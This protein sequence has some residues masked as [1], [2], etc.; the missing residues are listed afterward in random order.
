[1]T[2]LGTEFGV[3]VS[4]S[5]ETCSHVFRGSVQLQQID[6]AKGKETPGNT[7]VLHANEAA[8]IKIQQGDGV[9]GKAGNQITAK[10]IGLV[11]SRADFNATAFVLP[12]QMRQY[13]EQQRLKP[14]RRWQAYSQK[15]RNDPALVA[16]YPFEQ[17]PSDAST[18]VLPNRSAAG[19]ALDGRVAGGDW[20][21][22]RLPGKMALYFHGPHSGDHV[23][24]P[25]PNRFEFPGA[26]T[27]AIWCKLLRCDGMRTK[28]QRQ[29]DAIVCTLIAKS[30]GSWRLHQVISPTHKGELLFDTDTSALLHQTSTGQHYTVGRTCITP[31]VGLTSD[32]PWRFVVAVYQPVG[33]I[34][35]KRLYLD[36]RLDGSSDAPLPRSGNKAPVWLGANSGHGDQEFS[37]NREFSGLIDEV[38]IFSRA[39]SA[40]EI[41]A[42][43]AA[44]N[45]ATTA[46]D[47]A[48]ANWSK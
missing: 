7:I 43:F 16:Y 25:E 21:D 32:S 45:P 44:G 9:K 30:E 23:E 24:L 29:E 18:S 42:M 12:D 47:G 28:P 27:V 48:N 38:A 31:P 41:A 19:K 20:V 46:E 14:L 17:M 15:L 8:R 3:E 22:G 4:N 6:V 34:A 10:E 11:L 13:A 5:G 33:D 26:F 35:Q 2:D 40:E 37:G 36:G 39:L 1:V